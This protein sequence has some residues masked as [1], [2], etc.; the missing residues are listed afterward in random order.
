MPSKSTLPLN[1][2]SI[3]SGMVDI[4]AVHQNE[5]PIIHEEW[6]WDAQ[7]SEKFHRLAKT[8]PVKSPYATTKRPFQFG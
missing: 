8:P 6:P 1:A 2:G 3:S 5:L 7:V 4:G